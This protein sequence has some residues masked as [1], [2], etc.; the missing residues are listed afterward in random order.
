[1]KIGHPRR[2]THLP[3]PV[4]QVRAVSF[5]QGKI[6]KKLYSQAIVGRLLRLLS[7]SC[8]FWDHQ[9][10]QDESSSSGQVSC[11]FLH[12]TTICHVF[13]GHFYYDLFPQ[14]I[15]FC[16]YLYIVWIDTYIHTYMHTCIHAYMHTCI[17][18]YMHTCIHAY[19]HTCMHACMH[20]Y[21]HTYI[22]TYI[23]TLHMCVFIYPYTM[24]IYLCIVYILSWFTTTSQVFSVESGPNKFLTCK[25]LGLA[26]SQR[27]SRACA[28]SIGRSSVCDFE[29]LGP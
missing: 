26:S 17:H 22:H 14:H 24:C 6:L 28:S 5:R 12:I 29:S 20:A 15:H 8:W 4:F 18:A 13:F 3:T 11:R 9:R 25:A 21:M 2:K 27:L 1:M 7:D 23:H 10:V 16:I 19:M